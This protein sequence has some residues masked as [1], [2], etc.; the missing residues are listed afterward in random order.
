MSSASDITRP[1]VGLATN[2]FIPLSETQ[3]LFAFLYLS[4]QSATLLFWAVLLVAVV[5]DRQFE[6]PNNLL[7]MSLALADIVVAATG[8]HS[9]LPIV[10]NHGNSTGFTGMIDYSI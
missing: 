9:A 3:Y 2:Q 8:F 6:N 4:L 7:V 5:R 10:L 1:I